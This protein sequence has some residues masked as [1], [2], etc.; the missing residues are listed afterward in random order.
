[1]SPKDVLGAV[2]NGPL[3]ITLLLKHAPHLSDRLVSPPPRLSYGEK[4][5]M[6]PHLS[7]NLQRGHTASRTAVQSIL[8]HSQ[9]KVL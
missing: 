1:M 3:S 7:F 5:V 2:V 6:R 4:A 9:N 8:L